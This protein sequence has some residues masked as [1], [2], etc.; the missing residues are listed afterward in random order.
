MTDT[1]GDGVYISNLMK[2][3]IVSSLAG[4]KRYRRGWRG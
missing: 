4:G 3:D 1:R 2:S